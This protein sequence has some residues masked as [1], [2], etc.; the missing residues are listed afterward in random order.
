M[1]IVTHMCS[2]RSFGESYGGNL[3][4]ITLLGDWKDTFFRLPAT[5]LKS[6][7]KQLGSQERDRGGKK[8]S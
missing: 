8:D 5:L 7:P 2:L 6:R 1:V 4:N 3:F